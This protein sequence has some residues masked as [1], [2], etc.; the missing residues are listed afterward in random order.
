[1]RDP[2]RAI[3]W[4]PNLRSTRTPKQPLGTLGSLFGCVSLL[5]L[6]PFRGPCWVLAPR[7]CLIPSAR[8]G[9]RATAA[10]GRA[11]AAGGGHSGAVLLAPF[12]GLVCFLRTS[13]LCPVGG[14]GVRGG[15][16]AALTVLW[17][18]W[19]TRVGLAASQGRWTA[20]W[21]PVRDVRC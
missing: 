3:L 2:Q 13:R 18:P 21:R 10:G 20:C 11:R 8:R 12:F 17:G 5:E 16:G 7:A 9:G 6:G 15:R 1:M 14:R 4:V 19:L